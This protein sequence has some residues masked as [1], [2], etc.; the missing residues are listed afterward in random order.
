MLT[1]VN[2]VP[3]K[4]GSVK[5]N[6]RATKFLSS[7]KDLIEVPSY[8]P[9]FTLRGYDIIREGIKLVPNL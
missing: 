8:Q 3:I 5:V 6:P 9:T 7:S 1:V 2:E 4:I